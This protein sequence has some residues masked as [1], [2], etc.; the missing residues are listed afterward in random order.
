MLLKKLFLIFMVMKELKYCDKCHDTYEVV[1]DHITEVKLPKKCKSLKGE[2][3]LNRKQDDS[4]L[5]KIVYISFSFA[6]IILL[7][8]VVAM[9]CTSCNFSVNL[10]HSGREGSIDEVDE[11]K[12]DIKPNLNLTGLPPI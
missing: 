4:F 3:F 5:I 8:T 11:A 6:L 12:P 2:C 1:H 9:C 7:L 10:I